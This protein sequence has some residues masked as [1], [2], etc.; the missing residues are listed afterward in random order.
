M[1]FKVTKLLTLVPV[2]DILKNTVV[3]ETGLY[4]V[5]HSFCP[6]GAEVSCVNISVVLGKVS[7]LLN[8]YEYNLLGH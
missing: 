2:Y 4:V 5:M 7:L 1:L 6:F 8:D 3:N